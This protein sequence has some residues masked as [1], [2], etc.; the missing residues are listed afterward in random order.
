MY[1][2]FFLSI[3]MHNIITTTLRTI[4]YIID[5]ANTPPTAARDVVQTSHVLAIVSM[6]TTLQCNNVQ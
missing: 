2:L 1:L 6:Q 5:T 4:E 3:A